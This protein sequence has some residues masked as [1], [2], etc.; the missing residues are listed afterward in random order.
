VVKAK[1]IIIA[2]VILVGGIIAFLAFFQSEE[3]KVKK[4][5]KRV[6]KKVEKTPE[7]SIVVSATKANRIGEAFTGICKVQA[8]AYSFSRD[9]SS[10]EL[11]THILSMRSQYS[12]ISV[13]LY[14][15]VID[16]PEKG[17]AQAVFT[18]SMEGKLTTGEST[19]DLHELKCKLRKIEGTWRI[20]EVEIV[21]VLKK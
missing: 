20:E 19:A 15:F 4:Q 14:D 18:A 16:F 21:E 12:E 13:K 11:S 10:D 7:E 2:G 9:V 5:F 6:A 3:A 17:I 8:P 1:H